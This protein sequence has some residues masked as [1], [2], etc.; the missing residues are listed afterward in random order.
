MTVKYEEKKNQALNKTYSIFFY[1]SCYIFLKK[2]NIWSLLISMERILIEEMYKRL[3]GD[4]LNSIFFYISC[5]VSRAGPFL[6]IWR[7]GS[8]SEKRHVVK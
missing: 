6:R 1:I 7:L 5:Y 8:I 2:I 3:N 4:D